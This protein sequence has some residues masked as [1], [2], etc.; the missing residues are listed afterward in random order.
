[1][2]SDLRPP[3][4]AGR[5][6]QGLPVNTLVLASPPGPWRGAL[7]ALGLLWLALGIIYAGALTAMVGIWSRSD[8]FAHA[9]VVPPIALW[10][11]WRKRAE[12]ALHLPRP[13]PV[14]L[15]PFAAMALLWLLGE[16]VAVNAATQFAATALLVLAVPLVLG[17][18]VATVIL[19]PLAYLFF[20]VPIGEF[21]LP[22]LMQWTADFT[23]A[24]LRLSGV[25]VYREGLQ[26]I[27]PT[28]S[29]SVVEACS[30]VRYL[31]A[32]FMV[33]S[34]FAYLNYR[35]AK[36]RWI[37]ALVS[38]L[39]P[40]L[41]NWLRAYMIVML[42]HL[43]GNQIAV[44]AD[45][46]IY[47]WVFFGIVITILFVIGAR[48]AEDPADA[49]APPPGELQP[50]P[51]TGW[52]TWAAVAAAV[53]LALLPHGA[54]QRIEGTEA[55]APVQL[56]PVEPGPGW[57]RVDD[58]GA[59]MG[60]RPAFRAPSAEQRA[61]YQGGGA[62]VDLYLAYYRGQDDQRKL[63]SSSNVLVPS[64]DKAWNAIETR[65][66]TVAVGARQIE[67]RQTTLVPAMHAREPVRLVVWQVYWLNG[68]L[69]ARDVSAK[70]ISAWQR[71]R[72]EPD[73]SAAIVV[74]AADR[75]ERPADAPLR[76][77]IDANLGHIERGLQAARDRH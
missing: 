51:G 68:S 57:Q 61:R 11:A 48:W 37:F 1:V 73:E 38:L 49:V 60:W 2:R 41:A 16:L 21:L 50:R 46:L 25:P 15:L 10:L 31:M 26:F 56:A 67:V 14:W 35:S 42:G 23:V 59:D 13:S 7:P 52:H 55:T 24:A 53:V 12:L 29:W 17:T 64:S 63:V 54:L 34:L 65:W 33:G 40:I 4:G 76:S 72:G 69:S 20:A 62:D 30:G 27:I 44:G 22:I 77:F 32:S 66:R 39:V 36:R 18:R 8:T 28:G 71:L 43:S 70:L 75:P 19:F 6:P 5:G 74:Y 45:H 9:F 47:G 3:G 58:T